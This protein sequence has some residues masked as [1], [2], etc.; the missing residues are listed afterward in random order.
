MLP[1]KLAVEKLNI[2]AAAAAD[3]DP[4]ITQD[5]FL[6]KKA[7]EC[8]QCLSDQIGAAV[9]EAVATGEMP[10]LDEKATADAML[11]YLE[12]IQ[13]LAKARNDPEIIL[14]LGA[15]MKSI[16]LPAGSE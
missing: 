7:D 11:A 5:E 9:A 13:L 8:L 15:A 3:N 14:R 1:R 2:R 6:R 12:G 10:L 4:L 16:R